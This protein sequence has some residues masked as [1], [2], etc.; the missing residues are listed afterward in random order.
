ME[1]NNAV[2][3]E[4]RKLGEIAKITMGQSPDGINYTDNP[5]YNILVQGNADMKNGQVV[6]RVWTK[7]ITKTAKKGDIILSVRAPVGEVGKTKYNVVLGRGVSGVEGNE[8]VFQLLSKM[9]LENYWGKYSAGS[10]FESI[11][12]N[13]IKAAIAS[14]PEKQEQMK[15][16]T[17]LKQLDDT[18]ALH[19]RKLEKIKALKTA[20][21]SEMFAAEGETKPKRRFAG[22]TDDWEQRKLCE[23]AKI[24]MGQSPE[25]VNYTDN[26]RDYVLV[27]GNADMQNGHVV[28]RVWTKQITKTAK[29]GDIILSVRAPVGDVGKT[30]YDVV[31]GRGVSALEGN[32]FIFQLLSKMKA[33]NYWFKYSTG[34]TFESI[35]SNEIKE[36]IVSAPEKQEQMKIGVFFKQL[37]KT[38]TLHQRKLQKLQNIKKAYLNEMFI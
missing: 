20:Y 33:E 19:Q 38:I 14:V 29:K 22:F 10:T 27:Q 21:L 35:N 7:Q 17:F 13:E 24:T 15:I 9:K 16:G 18:I 26:P 12:S 4:Q 6:P 34:S 8:F 23:L 11:K 31:L 5:K 3:W 30:N 37:D 28:P 36:A 2:A 1:F 25:G 32:E